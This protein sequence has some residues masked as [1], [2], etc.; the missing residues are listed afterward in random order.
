[1]ITPLDK[2]KCDIY[3]EKFSIRRSK[4]KRPNDNCERDER[5]ERFWKGRKRKVLRAGVSGA[6]D[7][8]A[9]G[10]II[11]TCWEK[12]A[13]ILSWSDVANPVGAGMSYG[14]LGT[15]SEPRHGVVAGRNGKCGRVR[16]ITFIEE[17]SRLADVVLK[18]EQR[19]M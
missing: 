15:V 16:C 13:W 17:I 18:W 7:Q 5:R 14:G 6:G 1:M 9:G 2:V 8:R 3:R 10:N 11:V 4:T 19:I 12:H